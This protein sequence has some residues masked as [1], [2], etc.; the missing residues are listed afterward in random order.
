MWGNRDTG[1]FVIIVLAFSAYGG[2]I[3][4]LLLKQILLYNLQLKKLMTC[5]N[6]SVHTVTHLVKFCKFLP[7]R[8]SC[9]LSFCMP[10]KTVF[11]LHWGMSVCVS[12]LK[13]STGDP[14]LFHQQFCPA[15][16]TLHYTCNITTRVLLCLFSIFV[17]KL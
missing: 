17:F 8:F 1:V 6:T 7:F 11:P 13:S 3:L 9:Q 10:R 14:L 16:S 2:L 15:G 5:K 12:Q 4:V